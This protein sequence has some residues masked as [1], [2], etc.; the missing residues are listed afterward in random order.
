[1]FPLSN[2]YGVKKNF[3]SFGKWNSLKKKY[4]K[5]LSLDT[6]VKTQKLY[7]FK[8]FCSIS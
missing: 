7:Y 8:V 2:Q 1:M 6:K 3:V 4:R 5:L